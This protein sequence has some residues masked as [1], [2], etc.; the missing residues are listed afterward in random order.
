MNILLINPNTSE[1]VMPNMGLMLLHSYVKQSH[2]VEI[3]DCTFAPRTYIALVQKKL[4]SFT[5]KIV[6]ITVNIYSFAVALEIAKLIKKN[7]EHVRIILGGVFASLRP[8]IAISAQIIDAICIGDGE[9]AFSEYIGKEGDPSRLEGIEGIWFKKPGGPIVRNPYRAFFQ[10][11][12]SVPYVDWNDWS[13]KSYLNEGICYLPRSAQLLG[14]RG[15]PDNCKYCSENARVSNSCGPWFRM[16]APE[17]IMAE[18]KTNLSRYRTEGVKS[19]YFSDV[20]FQMEKDEFIRFC[21]LYV[22]NGFAE[23][24]P[25]CCKIRIDRVD[26]EWALHASRAGC[27]L[28]LVRVTSGNTEMKDQVCQKRISDDEVEKGFQRLHRHG[29]ATIATF[30]YGSPSETFTDVRRYLRLAKRINALSTFWHIYQPLPEVVV[31]KEDCVIYQE[32]VPSRRM[33]IWVASWWIRF[34]QL[35]SF[36]IHGIQM[37]GLV[38]VKD[39]IQYF[40]PSRHRFLPFFHKNHVSRIQRE[41]LYHYLIK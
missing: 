37:K 33:S 20:S 10:H 31:D 15:C 27:K 16:R 17:H 8:E 28:A 19:L 13:F 24:F 1:S 41:T 35:K 34:Y 38:F 6:G 11:I 30:I 23:E 25:W 3:V 4:E 18:I 29:I 36:V 12:N 22:E 32:Q 39:V 7:N 5:P 2:Q 14:S 40:F 26:D 21:H 9:E